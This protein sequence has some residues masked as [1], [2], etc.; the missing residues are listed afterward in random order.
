MRPENQHG[1]LR[2]GDGTMHPKTGKSGGG[3]KTLLYTYS[4][5]EWRLA[6]GRGG[7]LKSLAKKRQTRLLKKHCT[8]SICG[9]IN[10]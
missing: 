8:K 2:M 5:K 9:G 10:K 7:T 3:K 1:R 4:G 6:G